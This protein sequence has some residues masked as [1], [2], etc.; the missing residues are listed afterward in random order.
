[1]KNTIQNNLKQWDQDYR[2]LDAGD[3]W[4]G[5]ADYCGKDYRDWKSSLIQALIK[6]YLSTDNTVLEIAPGHGRWSNEMADHCKKLILIDLSPTCIDICKERFSAKKNIEYIVN[7]GKKLN[8]VGDMSVDFIWSFDSFV[9]MDKKIISSYLA[10]IKRVLKPGGIAIIHHAN[11]NNRF[12]WLGFIRHWGEVGKQ[13]FKLVSMG[14]IRDHDGWR[15]N[16]SKS[17]IRKIADLNNLGIS[18]QYQF[19][20]DNGEFGVPR[21]NDYISE[22]TN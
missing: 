11:R 13:F 17:T 3:E 6:P 12:L 5:Q 15:S 19:W 7:N 16:I 8:G 18:R 22:I 20:D 4:N 9:H 10:E 14:R 2:W 1:M 21:F